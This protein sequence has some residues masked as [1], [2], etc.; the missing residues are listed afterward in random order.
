VRPY[1][2]DSLSGRNDSGQVVHTHTH[3]CAAVTV[4]GRPLYAAEN[5]ITLAMC[6]TDFSGL[7]VTTYGLKAYKREMSSPPTLQWNMILFYLFT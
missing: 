5:V 7:P 2:R 6:Y 4:N 1:G 3:T